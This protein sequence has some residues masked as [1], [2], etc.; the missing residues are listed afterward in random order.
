MHGDGFDQVP[1]VTVAK[2]V[3]VQ[4][5]QSGKPRPLARKRAVPAV[6]QKPSVPA[7]APPHPIQPPRRPQPPFPCSCRFGVLPLR[8]GRK[9][10]RTEGF[11]DREANGKLRRLHYTRKTST[12]ERITYGTSGKRI[13]VFIE[14]AKKI[15]KKVQFFSFF[16]LSIQIFFVSLQYQTKTDEPTG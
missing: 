4:K 7:A 15:S 10:N 3:P 1:K 16:V 2:T 13:F 14:A 9:P 11:D 12:A 5:T 6:T 8:M